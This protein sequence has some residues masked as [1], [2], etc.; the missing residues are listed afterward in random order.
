M[1]QNQKYWLL[2]LVIE[3]TLIIV[4]LTA[5]YF[6]TSLMVFIPVVAALAT[7]VYITNSML[8]EMEIEKSVQVWQLPTGEV[9]IGDKEEFADFMKRVE[10]G[11]IKLDGE[12][13]RREDEV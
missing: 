3:W 12:T 13:E 1:D 10:S 11:E 2:R 6:H 5:I 9:F 7:I 8:G 4:G